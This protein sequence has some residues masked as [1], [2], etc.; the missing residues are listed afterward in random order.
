MNQIKQEHQIELINLYNRNKL[1]VSGAI[2]VL[3]STEK[4]VV[5]KLENE[6][7][8]I[9]GNKLTI[10]KLIPDHKLLTVLGEIKGIEYITKLNK[11]SFIKKVFK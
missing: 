7:M 6:F 8:A 9:K 1:D 5:V 3:S 4:E 11:K 2:E 10:S